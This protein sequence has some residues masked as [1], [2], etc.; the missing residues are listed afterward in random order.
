MGTDHSQPPRPRSHFPSGR[1]VACTLPAEYT[2]GNVQNLTPSGVGITEEHGMLE[3]PGMW[4]S[5]F[6]GTLGSII[7]HMHQGKQEL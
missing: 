2:K 3:P 7:A 5:I 4:G 6:G 1:E